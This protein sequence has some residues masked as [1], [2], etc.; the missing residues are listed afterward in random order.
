VSW[1]EKCLTSIHSK[2]NIVNKPLY[3][4]DDPFPGQIVRPHRTYDDPK[5]KNNV[6]Y[7]ILA[8]YL[9]LLFKLHCKNRN[10]RWIPVIKAVKANEY[11]ILRF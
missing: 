2:L 6:I 1:P 10:K 7:R 8:L 11:F 5:H 3:N 4:T 9:L